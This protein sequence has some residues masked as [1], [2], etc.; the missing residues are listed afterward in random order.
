[1]PERML[2]HVLLFKERKN[3]H[4]EIVLEI[5]NQHG[6][7]YYNIDQW[8]TAKR[9]LD[10]TVRV[11]ENDMFIDKPYADFILSADERC[12]ILID[13]ELEEIMDAWAIQQSETT[14]HCY[15][16]VNHNCADAVIW[17]LNRYA[18]M[19]KPSW[20]SRPMTCHHAFFCCP[21][22][23]FFNCISIPE[24]VMASITQWVRDNQLGLMSQQ[25]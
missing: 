9:R 24:R 3:D 1:M 12:A 14:E 22:P 16:A 2:V 19:P 17:F 15:Q 6:S 4:L 7:L 11:R 8:A 13:A 21:I 23:S 20:D 18:N 5:Q 25:I 10:K